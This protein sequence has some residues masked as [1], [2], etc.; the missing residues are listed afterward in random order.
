MLLRSPLPFALSFHHLHRHPAPAHPHLYILISPN[1]IPAP[2]PRAASQPTPVSSPPYHT[3]AISQ[4]PCDIRIHRSRVGSRASNVK[5]NLTPS[6]LRPSRLPLA[7]CLPE[8][9][10]PS[11]LGTKLQYPSR[12]FSSLPPLPS[13][14]PSPSSLSP[15]PLPPCAAIPPPAR[16][17]SCPCDDGA[18][19]HKLS[20][21]A[22][23]NVGRILART[24]RD[25]TLDSACPLAAACVSGPEKGRGRCSTFFILGRGA[26]IQCLASSSLGGYLVGA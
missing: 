15:P 8:S 24:R 20:T 5:V 3:R 1:P 23:R 17:R 25:R 4:W 6:A 18:D 2:A 12:S 21:V 16:Y 19:G 26:A 14:H 9:A 7:T 11:S 10:P 13:Y 22:R